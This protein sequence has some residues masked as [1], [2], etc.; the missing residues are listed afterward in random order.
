MV[1][2][3]DLPLSAPVP[4]VGDPLSLER[5]ERLHMEAVL[6]RSGSRD[7]AARQLGIDSSTLYRKRTLYSLGRGGAGA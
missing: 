6:A 1:S 4:S 2:S 3:L 7:A 5:M